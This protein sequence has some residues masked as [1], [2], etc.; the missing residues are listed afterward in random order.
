M[1]PRA[2]MIAACMTALLVNAARAE[3]ALHERIDQAIESQ[4]GPLAERVSDAEFLRRVYLDLAGRIPST[5]QAQAFFADADAGKRAKLIDRLLASPDYARRMQ[6][7]IT[8]WL[9]ERRA[10][11]AVSDPEWNQYVERAFAENRAWDQFVRDLIAADGQSADHRAAI[12][13]FADG[14]RNDPHQLTKDVAR[15][16]LGMN[17]HCSQCHNDPNVKDFKQADYFG[18][19]AYLRQ[20]QVARDKEQ[21]AVLI[22]T[23]AQ[24]KQEFQSVFTQIKNATGPRLPNGTEIAI[25]KFEKGQ[26]MAVPAKAGVPGIPKFRPR[27]LLA[28]DLT[29]AIN[30]RFVRTSVNH[31]WFLMLGR[32]LVHPL[33]MMHDSNPPSHPQVLDLLAEEFVKQ[34][35]D[36]KHLLREI[37]LS[38][39]YQR[40]SMLPNG[41]KSSEVPPQ[42]FRVAIPK[43]LSAE[44][45]AFSVM[46]AT[47]KLEK[48]LAAPVPKP[49]RF[50]HKDYV[51]GRLPPPDNLPDVLQLFAATFG[52]PAGEPEV[53]FTPSVAQSL[54][55]LNDKL[56]LDWLDPGD[57][58]LVRRLAKR[59]T[60]Q[61]VAE[62]LYLTILTRLPSADEQAELAAYLQSQQSRRSAALSELAWALM[63]SAEFRLNH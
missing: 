2:T 17:L 58:N 36:V 25:P 52:N 63:T 59:S 26:E 21:K 37:A 14:G 28:A 55:L 53:H 20:T 39:V 12:R 30:A 44:Q 35:F 34:H 32:G 19:Y 51:N 3:P 54:F 23:V 46:Q 15:L 8:V 22:E 11:Q 56:V 49:S 50:T 61:A 31:F 45:L 43:S 16:F 41:L 40:S 48:V 10:G 38:R 18:I 6:Q 60:P 5:E 4:N 47:G 1:T 27:S 7:A 24:D 9:L 33:D 62:E 13:F 57:D 29:A 42:S